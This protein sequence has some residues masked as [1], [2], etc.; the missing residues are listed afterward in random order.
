MI[1]AET[2]ILAEKLAD[3]AGAAIRPFFRQP[4]DIETKHDL[5]PVTA[6]DRASEAVMRAIIEAERPDHGIIGEEFGRVREDA[7]YIWVL[8]P[9]DGT[10]AFV[11]GRPLFGTLIALLEDGKP[12]LGV[13]DQP[14]IGDRWVGAEQRPTLFNGDPARTRGCVGLGAARIGTTSPQAFDA[15]SFARFERLRPHA[16]DTLYGGD[17]H[18]YGLVA[19][20]HLDLVVEAGLQLYDFAALVPVVEGAGG[21]MTDWQGRPLDRHSDGRVIA[22]GDPKLIDEA[23]RLLA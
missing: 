8:D 17:C 14:I 16:C 2:I 6:A 9:I 7:R 10:R 21:R 23:L 5:S 3:A 12:V 4:C 15:D 20:G 11:S 19:S 1:D 13:I 22:A 18:N